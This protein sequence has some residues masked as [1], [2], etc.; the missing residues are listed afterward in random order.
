VREFLTKFTPTPEFLTLAPEI[1]T[2]GPKFSLYI[3]L[4][5]S[6]YHW[7]GASARR[8]CATASRPLSDAGHPLHAGAPQNMAIILPCYCNVWPGRLA[9]PAHAGGQMIVRISKHSENFEGNSEIFGGNCE[10]LVLSR[11]LSE[12][13][14]VNVNNFGTK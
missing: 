1:L 3:D 4:K 6:L 9:M 13:F 8:A 2:M 11:K 14:E 7:G 5:F 10:K 12:K